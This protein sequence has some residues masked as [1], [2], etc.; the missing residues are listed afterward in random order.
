MRKRVWLLAPA[1]VLYVCDAGLTLAGQPDAYWT[2]DYGTAVEY[3]PLVRP[4]LTTGPGCF[5]AAA[6]LW[7]AA[8]SAI[9]LGWRHRYSGWLAVVVAIGHAIGVGSWLSRAE[10]FGS[11]V[12][13][14]YLAL[15]AQACA[16]SWR[17]Y[18]RN[19]SQRLS[20]P[21]P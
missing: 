19:D 12:A 6:A 9:I 21:C 8:V 13:I 18:S 14:A 15:A 3:N 1:A 10:P 20:E 5:T 7:L 17:Q 4:L 2:G 11:L 16:W